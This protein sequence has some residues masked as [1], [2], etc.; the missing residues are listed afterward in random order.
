[1][2]CTGSK[3]APAKTTVS[4]PATTKSVA[5]IGTIYGHQFSQPAR[6]VQWYNEYAK[7]NLDVKFVDLFSGEQKKPEFVAKFPAGQV[8]A[9]EEG[10]FKLSE[11]AAIL[12]YLA[13]GDA[14]VPSDAKEA[15]RVEQMLA[16]HLAKARK[17]SIEIIMPLFFVEE[18][19]EA[20]IAKGIETVQ[21]ILKFYDDLLSKQAYLAGDKLSLADFLF[22]PEVD[23]F[24]ILEPA[25]KTNV[26][27][28]FKSIVSYLDRLRKVDG[29][30][31][32]FTVASD[33]FKAV[34]AAKAAEAATKPKP[35][36]AI[37]G[38]QF[39][40][41]ARSV[42]WYNE[43][44]KKNIDVKIVDLFAG[45]HKAPEFVAKFPAGQVP[46]FE[47]GDFKLGESA[48]ILSYLARNDAIVPS[49]AKEAARV[50]Q[51]LAT[52]LAKARKLSIEI[53]MPLFFV[54]E[55]KEALI[56][57]GIEAVQPILKFYD[58][59]LSKQAYLAGDKLSLADF[60]FAP[61]VDQFLIL[62]PALKTNVIGNFKS[63]VSYLERLRKVDGYNANFTV[64]SDFFKAV[65][66]AKAA[67]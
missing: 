51:M 35:E 57:K 11:S 58:D 16:T 55:D 3:D 1:M 12:S 43:Y 21:P 14:I 45:E 23:Q 48:A 56:A 44:A 59:L 2:G 31:A 64:A 33:F 19:K 40:Q 65:S 41:P 7:K 28:N 36:V 25:L 67:Q 15:A 42:Q 60:L 8:P 17:L 22:A 62:E 39:S 24:L 37:Y 9:Y 47:E 61:E 5:V 54:E 27:G 66:A 29:Y 18:D 63:I 6:S 46:A 20:L 38:H 30:N 49:D 53:I 26:I 50:E 52:H 10:T 13:E 4:K 32:S 34:S